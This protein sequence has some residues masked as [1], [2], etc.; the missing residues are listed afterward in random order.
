MRL[1]EL[2]EALDIS[3]EKC[4]KRKDGK[5][6][7]RA[8]SR[9]RRKKQSKSTTATRGHKY[10]YPFYGYGYGHHH[11]DEYDGDTGDIGDIGEASTF[12]NT[13]GVMIEEI[14][15]GTMTEEDTVKL[16]PYLQNKYEFWMYPS[17]LAEQFDKKFKRVNDN[18]LVDRGANQYTLDW[19]L[20]N[21]NTPTAYYREM[22]PLNPLKLL[23]IEGL[24]GEHTYI[25]K[26]EHKERISKLAKDMLEKGFNKGAAI[27]VEVTREGPRIVEG[28]HRV[29]AAAEAGIRAIPTEW[30]WLGGTEMNE[31]HHPVQY[32]VPK[33]ERIYESS[34]PIEIKELSGDEIADLSW[35]DENK[36][37]FKRL[38][39]F[40]SREVYREH[41]FVALD[42]KKI[43]GVAGIEQN[44]RNQ[45]EY[46]IKHV[47][48]DPN[49]QGQKLAE[50]LLEP[51]FAYAAKN[52]VKLKRSTYSTL[53]KERLERIFA[54]LRQ[55]YSGVGFEEPNPEYVFEERIVQAAFKLPNGEVVTSGPFHDKDVLPDEYQ[56]DD[57][58]K[59]VI[60]GFFTDEGRFLT[61]PEAAELAQLKKPARQRD[62]LHSYNIKGMGSGRVIPGWNPEKVSG[63][64]VSH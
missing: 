51:V 21:Q 44:P 6:D 18:P 11:H 43:V 26:P 55:K 22:L 5:C 33:N 30:R 47:S 13:G 1:T 9:K 42:G 3:E 45:E 10:G 50:R 27:L 24:S 2:F 58:L 29:R 7:Q 49:Y 14:F 59:S 4:K 64:L 34:Q 8:T 48:I 16:P 31:K 60:S 56:S 32:V 20:S 17:K 35:T 54:R 37:V 40:D 25:D 12:G 53:G 63:E 41:H 46:W 28:N 15:G 62:Q 36:D 52:K 19:L 57:G 23:K 38:K 61:R 39:Y